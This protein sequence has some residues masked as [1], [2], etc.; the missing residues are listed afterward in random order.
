MNKVINTEGSTIQGP[1]LKI[2]EN[3]FFHVF[4]KTYER[5]VYLLDFHRFSVSEMQKKIKNKQILNSILRAKQHLKTKPN[6]QFI[7][8]FLQKREEIKNITNKKTLFNE[9]M[10]KKIFKPNFPK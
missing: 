6:N 5:K 1:S 3:S 2:K 9:I 8:E 7:H 4:S 10:E